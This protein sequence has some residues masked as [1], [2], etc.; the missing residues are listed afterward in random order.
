MCDLER[1]ALRALVLGL[2]LPVT[3]AAADADVMGVEPTP[4]LTPQMEAQDRT[5]AGVVANHLLRTKVAFD[6]AGL[7]LRDRVAELAAAE[8]LLEE[9]Y[10]ESGYGAFPSEEDQ[11]GQLRRFGE[12]LTLDLK[13]IELIQRREKLRMQ[14]DLAKRVLG[15]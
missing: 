8:P 3:E 9:P 5:I 15:K 14:Y 4:I 10:E 2:A 13:L 6:L 12:T 11:W 1:H 7:A